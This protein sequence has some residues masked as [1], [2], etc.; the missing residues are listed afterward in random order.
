MYE[1]SVEYAEGKG[2]SIDDDLVALTCIVTL[3]PF[4]VWRL[5]AYGC[6][7]CVRLKVLGQT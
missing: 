6:R 1:K 2:W 3:V 5:A 4:T 7:D